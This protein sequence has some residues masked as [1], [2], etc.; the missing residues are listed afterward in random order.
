[1]FE[2]IYDGVISSLSQSGFLNWDNKNKL[3][4]TTYKS[5]IISIPTKDSLLG[6]IVTDLPSKLKVMTFNY[7]IGNNESIINSCEANQLKIK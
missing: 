2:E 7:S 1:M 6:N 4:D 5:P 3:S